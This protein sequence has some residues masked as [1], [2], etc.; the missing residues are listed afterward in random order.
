VQLQRLLHNCHSVVDS[1]TEKEAASDGIGV[2]EW[3]SNVVVIARQPAGPGWQW[4]G[5]MHM[6]DMYLLDKCK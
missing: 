6:C 3:G 1:D 4:H 2:S 5:K